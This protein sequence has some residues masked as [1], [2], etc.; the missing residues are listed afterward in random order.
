[1][2]NGHGFFNFGDSQFLGVTMGA[3]FT[4]GDLG[5]KWSSATS[6]TSAMAPCCPA[7]PVVHTPGVALLLINL[8]ATGIAVL[9]R[10][11]HRQDIW[12]GGLHVVC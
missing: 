1:M 4:S 8:A 9:L 2:Q 10:T 11:R 6:S 3:N 7:Y 5:M 12:A